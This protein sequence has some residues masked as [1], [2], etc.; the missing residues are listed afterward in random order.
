MKKELIIHDSVLTSSPPLK[1]EQDGGSKSGIIYLWGNVYCVLQC[2]SVHGES[3]VLD[4]LPSRTFFFFSFNFFFFLL[5]TRTHHWTSNATSSNQTTYERKIWWSM[6]QIHKQTQWLTVRIIHFMPPDSPFSPAWA[7]ADSVLKNDNNNNKRKRNLLSSFIKSFHICTD[8]YHREIQ[9]RF[10]DLCLGD[11]NKK[12]A[13]DHENH[14][15]NGKNKLEA[16]NSNAVSRCQSPTLHHFTLKSR[17]T[18]WHLERKPWEQTKSCFSLF[19]AF[20]FSFSS[21]Q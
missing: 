18:K 11:D 16:L 12:V 4:K 13:G 5:L 21:R 8:S 9:L 17:A 7:K 14:Q 20:A 1:C 2:F 6:I 10:F 19:C 15:L 3:R